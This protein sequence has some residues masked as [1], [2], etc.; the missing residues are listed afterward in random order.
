MSGKL[1]KLK[2]FHIVKWKAGPRLLK[3]LIK[4]TG[5]IGAGFFDGTILKIKTT[6]DSDGVIFVFEKPM[7]FYQTIEQCLLPL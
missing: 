5:L 2:P 1:K 6:P 3:V 4:K 7:Y